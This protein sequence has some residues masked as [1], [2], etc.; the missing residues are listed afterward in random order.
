MEGVGYRYFLCVMKESSQGLLWRA[1]VHSQ[2]VPGQP[3]FAFGGI[4]R[5]L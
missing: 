1:A 4:Y 3:N 5:L 2:S